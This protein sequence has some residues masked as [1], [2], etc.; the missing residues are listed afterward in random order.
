MNRVHRTTW[1]KSLLP[2]VN[3]LADE[4]EVPGEAESRQQHICV[5]LF[6]F[7]NY[8]CLLGGTGYNEDAV[9]LFAFW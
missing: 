8:P 5:G 1:E 6:V 7:S 4:G 3:T 9:F 2:F